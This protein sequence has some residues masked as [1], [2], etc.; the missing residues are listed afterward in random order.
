MQSIN[1]D[2]EHFLNGSFVST[3]ND[4]GDI[5]LVYF[6]AGSPAQND[7]ARCVEAN[8]ATIPRS[9]PRTETSMIS[10]SGRTSGEPMT[11]EGGA[12]TPIKLF[13]IAEEIAAKEAC[14]KKIEL[15]FQDEVRAGQKNKITRRWTKR[16]TRPPAPH[17]QRTASAYIS[18]AIA[19]SQR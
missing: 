12:G 7:R 4:P 8:E 6:A 14:G 10:P 5:D 1:I 11:P 15:W 13:A 9:M 2:V 19:R 18:G 16:G 17:D 3:K